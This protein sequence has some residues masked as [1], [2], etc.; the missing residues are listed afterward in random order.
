MSKHIEIDPV[1]A[2]NIASPRVM[3]LSTMF[4][5]ISVHF[6]LIFC[7]YLHPLSVSDYITSQIQTQHSAHCTDCIGVSA[8]R[9]R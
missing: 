2:P 5:D 3:F 8:Q 4:D 9:C 6:I 7:H 1:T